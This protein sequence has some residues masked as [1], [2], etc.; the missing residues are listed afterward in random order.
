MERTQ[1]LFR[2]WPGSQTLGAGTTTNLTSDHPHG[3]AV[4]NFPIIRVV[5]NNRVSSGSPVKFK[6][7]LIQD[8][9]RIGILDTITVNPGAS[10]TEIY[11]VPGL[12]LAID[13]TN[14]G[15]ID[16]YVDAFIYGFGPVTDRNC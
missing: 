12:C 1:L 11:D 3:I 14:N 7:I 16:S 5:F 2:T 9:E 6:I 8:R 15:T 10:V 13:A 4:F